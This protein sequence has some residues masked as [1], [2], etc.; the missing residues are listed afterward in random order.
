VVN[1][2]YRQGMS[3]SLKVGLNAVNKKAKAVI[4]VLADQPLLK[5][6]I[7]NKIV[8]EYKKV[9][10]SIVV[11]T[12]KG[13]KGNPVLF[14]IS[15]KG[16]LLKIQGDVGGRFVARNHENEIHMLEIDSPLILMDVDTKKDLDMLK[17]RY[18]D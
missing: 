8:E 14:D 10:A 3:T 5:T 13:K 6:W 18:W 2:N 16:E 15:L 1:K 4:F 17:E 12:Y 7:I 9:N 11:P